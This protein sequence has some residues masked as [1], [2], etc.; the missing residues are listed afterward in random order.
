M[1]EKGLFFPFSRKVLLK[2]PGSEK[3]V[4]LTQVLASSKGTEATSA[5]TSPARA[6]GTVEGLSIPDENR[7][8]SVLSGTL[9]LQTLNDPL[10][11]PGEPL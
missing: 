4:L 10:T 8:L 11:L 6:T 9:C 5:E 7:A 1:R 2:T 3:R